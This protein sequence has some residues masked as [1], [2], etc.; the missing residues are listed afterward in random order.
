MPSTFE[1]KNSNM[2]NKFL[3]LFFSLFFIISSSYAEVLEKIEITGLNVIDRGTVLSYLPIEVGDNLTDKT[4]ETVRE[5]LI[6]TGFF[7]Q[8]KTDLILRSLNISLNENPTVKYLDIENFK[9]NEV[10]SD[11]IILNLKKN[12]DLITGK[13]FQKK[14]L[15]NLLM[16]IKSL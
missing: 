1:N 12:H 7:S 2:K 11:E 9:D 6:K 5:S 3:L 13:I 14:N 8:V 4:I 15:E 16:Q 10:L